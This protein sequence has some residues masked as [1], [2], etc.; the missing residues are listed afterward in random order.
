MQWKTRPIVLLILAFSLLTGS[1]GVAATQRFCAMLG[2][3]AAPSAAKKMADMGCCSKKQKPA[4]PEAA[5]KVGKEKC[6]SVSTTH[7]KL[8]VE[9][10][11][12]YDKV[13]LVALP[14]MLVSSFLLP[15]VPTAAPATTWPLYS[16]SSP[17]LAGKELLHRLHIL[18]I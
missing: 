13:E 8:D 5:A 16:D 2:M 4:C 1:V 18:N 3:T 7:H 11:L 10:L 14:P 9:S 17:P 15:L 12:T 6:C